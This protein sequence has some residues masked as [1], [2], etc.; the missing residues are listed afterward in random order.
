MD[1][2]FDRWNEQ[3]KQFSKKSTKIMFHEREIWWCSLGINLGSEQMSLSRDF[4]RPVLIVRVFTQTM[5]WG[6]PLTTKIQEKPYRYPFSLNNIQNDALILQLRAF[7]QKRLIRKIGMLEMTS[8]QEIK[9][10][11]K[12]LL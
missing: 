9:L 5:F 8:F 2:D 6:I 10:F 7:D 4:S 1:A 11:V 12:E 3:K